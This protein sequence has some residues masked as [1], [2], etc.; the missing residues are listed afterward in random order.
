[1]GNRKTPQH[2]FCTSD[3]LRLKQWDLASDKEFEFMVLMRMHAWDL[4]FP[5]TWVQTGVRGLN[6]PLT[7][8][9]I[10]RD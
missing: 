1:M 9:R 4:C 8:D 10:T 2:G 3:R 6:L 7:T 5:R